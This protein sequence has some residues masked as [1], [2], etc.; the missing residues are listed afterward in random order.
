MWH[1]AS[2]HTS[3][4]KTRDLTKLEDGINSLIHLKIPHTF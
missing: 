4:M 2:F 3:I 1:L